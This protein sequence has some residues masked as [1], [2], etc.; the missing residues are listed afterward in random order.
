M[1][2]YDFLATG[3]DLGVEPRNAVRLARWGAEES[4]PTAF[5]GRSDYDALITAGIP[6]RG[7]FTGAEDNK[8]ADQVGP[9]RW[10]ATFGGDTVAY[11]PCYH[12]ACDSLDPISDGAD[13]GL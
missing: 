11:D 4:E 5:D 2:S 7:L 13:A 12:Q 1:S 3:T 9:L 10:L 8:T 6:A